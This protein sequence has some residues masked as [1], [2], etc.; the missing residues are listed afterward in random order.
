MPPSRF[1]NLFKATEKP[2]LFTSQ[3]IKFEVKETE[4]TKPKKISSPFQTQ[5]KPLFTPQVRKTE[6]KETDS[7]PTNNL[8][9]SAKTSGSSLFGPTS[10][11]KP[12]FAFEKKTSQKD[13]THHSLFSQAKPKI[14]DAS[15]L[16]SSNAQPKTFLKVFETPEDP[17]KRKAFLFLN[18][19]ESDVLFKVENEE[20]PAH[21]YILSEKCKFFKN[22]FESKSG[23]WFIGPKIS[24]VECWNHILQLFRFLKSKPQYSRLF[25]S[26][27]TKDRRF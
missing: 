17:T 14:F 27:S 5:D 4:N 18:K 23:Y 24:K 1:T 19:H 10:K 15:N 13:E 2:S 6:I 7:K 8:F 9:S 12:S 25:L 21:K 16:F 22:M 3:K 20:F 26:M 11:S